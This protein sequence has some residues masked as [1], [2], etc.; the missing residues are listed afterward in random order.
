MLVAATA[1]A[2]KSTS[3]RSSPRSL[4]TAYEVAVHV[5]LTAALAAG[6]PFFRSQSGAL[7]MPGFGRILPHR[8]MQ[9]VRDVRTR[10]IIQSSI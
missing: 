7:L 9:D 6:V 4:R 8:F 5:D 10:R 2:I 1:S 3:R